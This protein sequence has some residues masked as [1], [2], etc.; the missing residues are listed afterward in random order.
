MYQNATKSILDIQAKVIQRE[1]DRSR[2]QQR[3]EQMDTMRF[4]K[5]KQHIRNIDQMVRERQEGWVAAVFQ[6]A[7]RQQK[8]EK[9]VI[10]WN[11]R[12][13]CGFFSKRYGA[14]NSPFRSKSN[15]RKP[16]T[17]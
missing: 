15:S 10:Q 2:K 8:D 6:R 9:S 11:E 4:Y 5:D 1:G 14:N 12:N 7:S 16:S 3:K 13:N 17:S